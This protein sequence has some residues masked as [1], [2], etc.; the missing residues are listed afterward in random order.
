MGG[1][2]DK[3]YLHILSPVKDQVEVFSSFFL[4]RVERWKP[5]Q[6]FGTSLAHCSSAVVL[7]AEQFDQNLGSEETM[8]PADQQPAASSPH[9]RPHVNAVGQCR[10]IAECFET[11]PS[12]LIQD[13]IRYQ[14]AA[15]RRGISSSL[16]VMRS[17]CVC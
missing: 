12:R 8:T 1:L 7:P 14:K 6:P 11:R 5:S 9:P 15:T 16:N 13:R 3:R 4:F 17:H 10:L 2:Q